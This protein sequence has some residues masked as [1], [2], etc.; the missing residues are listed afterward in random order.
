[1]P[2]IFFI[3]VT[4]TQGSEGHACR[5]AQLSS[6]LA[7]AEL[8]GLDPEFYLQEILTVIG[9]YL[10]RLMLELAPNRWVQTRCRLIEAGQLRYIDLA[11]VTGFGLAFRR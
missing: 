9:K 10:A 5:T 1:V 2:C 3:I 4:E 7:G 11:R 8:L 6:L